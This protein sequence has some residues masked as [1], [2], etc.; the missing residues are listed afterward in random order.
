MKFELSPSSSN[1]RTMP[2][3][4]CCVSTNL[5]CIGRLYTVGLPD[6]RPYMLES[7]MSDACSAW[8]GVVLL[9][10]DIGFPESSGQ[11]VAFRAST[12]QVLVLFPGW[13][14]LT[15]PIIRTAVGR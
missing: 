7:T 6:K 10:K 14:E 13:A 11:V 15:Q 12:P 4:K 9:V 5:E 8:S 1:Y 2:T 3:R